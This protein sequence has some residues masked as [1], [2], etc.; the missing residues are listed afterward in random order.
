[1]KQTE[2]KS[3]IMYNDYIEMFSLLNMEER[4]RL[5][6]AIFN[7]VIAGSEESPLSAASRVAFVFIK[8]TLDRDRAAYELKCEKNAANG[9]KGGR[10]KKNQNSESTEHIGDNFLSEKTERLF[11]KPKK[12]DNDNDS[13][14]GIDNE[15]EIDIDI[16]SGTD[17]GT[18][19]G[20]DND[21][22]GSAT[23]SEDVSDDAPRQRKV[24]KEINVLGVP[25][26]Y[27]SERKDRI[28][29]YAAKHGRELSEVVL[30]WW[31]KEN[32][33]TKRRYGVETPK[34][35]AATGSSSDQPPPES[36]DV[37]D[38]FAAALEKSRRRVKP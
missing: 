29:R 18:E 25:E 21:V 37:D 14:T 22:M 6:T 33:A 10:P 9:A 5:I 13:G 35:S 16:D 3:F 12:A 26:L 4:G 8:N 2:K 11:S 23:L 28:E 36:F 7:Y 30:D 17:S 34:R 27:I 24:L 31:Q 15:I 38:F 1:M 20:T 32:A 19:S